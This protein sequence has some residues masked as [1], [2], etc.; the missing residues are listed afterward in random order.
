[1][2]IKSIVEGIE[3]AIQPTGY[4]LYFGMMSMYQTKRNPK[5]KEVILQPFNARPLRVDMTHYDTELTMWV[6]LRR[7]VSEKYVTD[8]GN[9]KDFV[10]EL[11]TDTTA[12][13]KALGDSG[14]V[15]IKQKFETIELNYYEADAGASVNSQAFYTFTIPVRIW[16]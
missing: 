16:I 11:L 13:L 15:L 4:S 9:N 12:I 1:M 8:G 5:D 14:K 10:N 6:G 3:A 7:N 2:N